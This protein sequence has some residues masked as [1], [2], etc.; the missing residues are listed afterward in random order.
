MA[1]DDF[2]QVLVSDL[3]WRPSTF[4]R[5]VSVKDVAIT[6]GYEMQLVR[7]APGAAFPVHEHRG[8]EFIFVI[9]GELIQAGRRLTAGWASVARAG[10]IDE[11]VH[12]E[13]GCTFLLVDRS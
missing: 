3:P 6:D 9:E 11:K 10:S 2:T 8:P 13:I 7:F 5:G 4:A 12:S 1:G